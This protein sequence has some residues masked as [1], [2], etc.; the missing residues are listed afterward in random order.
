MNLIKLFIIIIFIFNVFACSSVSENQKEDAEN[1]IV[2]GRILNYNNHP[3][4]Y[5]IKI[6]ERNLV[7]YNGINHTEFID[8]DGNFKFEFKKQYTSDIYL[9]YGKMINLI[10]GSG[11]SVFVEFDADEFLDN[12]AQNFRETKTLTFS[13]DRMLTNEQIKLFHSLIITD[14]QIN[15][16]MNNEV[17][18]NSQE[19]L[20]YLISRKSEWK[21]V[22]DSLIKNQ[23]LT[24]EFIDWSMLFINYQF[25]LELLHYT[26]YNPHMNGK[27]PMDIPISFHNALKEIALDNENAIICT[28]YN[29]YLHEYFMAY[30]FHSSS[31]YEKLEKSNWKYSKSESFESELKILLKTIEMEYSG[32]ANEALLSQELFRLLDFYDRQDVFEN[33]YPVYKNVIRRS[34]LITLDEKYA[35]IKLKENT[36][37]DDKSIKKVGKELKSIDSNVFEEILEINKGKVIYIDFWA[38]WCG[39]CLTELPNSRKLHEELKDKNVEF[40]YLCVK[41]KVDDWK[42]K[43]IEYKLDGSHYLLTDSQYDILSQRFQISG[44]PHYVLID[45]NGIVAKNGSQ[46]RP[47]IVKEDIEDLIKK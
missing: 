37:S 44:I 12:E 1:V 41:S 29:W 8:E 17:T 13:G 6:H 33:L 43:L 3:D 36:L 10:V 30:T 7:N 5:T 35:E 18:L 21:K 40:V 34:L 23:K 39:P 20:D 28:E 11:D 47:N 15:Q 42:G 2:A 22:L 14:E 46:L 45:K 19:Y 24:K 26:W 25:G 16:F 9:Q 4:N 32:I 31:L 27:E 38:T